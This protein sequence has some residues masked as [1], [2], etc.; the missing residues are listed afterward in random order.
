M[1]Y[2]LMKRSVLFGLSFTVLST[3]AI[4]G[5][6][7]GASGGGSP[8]ASHEAQAILSYQDRHRDGGFIVTHTE[9]SG[10]EVKIGPG[11]ETAFGYGSSDTKIQTDSGATSW[12]RSIQ[13]GNAHAAKGAGNASGFSASFVKVQT[14]DGK[15]YMFKGM[16]DTSASVGPDGTSTKKY[17]IAKSASGR[18]RQPQ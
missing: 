15:F 7:G 11:G 9:L 13:R 12:K 16:T 6:Y 5:G 2:A 4:A 3:A 17:G 1:P 14:S 18:I 10:A 8:I